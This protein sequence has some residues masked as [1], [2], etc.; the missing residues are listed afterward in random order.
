MLY[1]WLGLGSGLD[2]VTACLG[3]EA[4]NYGLGFGL[5]LVDV[6]LTLALVSCTYGLVNIPAFFHIDLPLTSYWLGAGPLV[7]VRSTATLRRKALDTPARLKSVRPASGEL[8]EYEFGAGLH[9]A[10]LRSHSR[11]FYSTRASSSSSSSSEFTMAPFSR[12]SVAPYTGASC[13]N[14]GQSP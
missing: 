3:L 8:T 7:F 4:K 2:L 5:G 12:C 6:A 1:F 13:K 9:D 14:V 10:R 11:G